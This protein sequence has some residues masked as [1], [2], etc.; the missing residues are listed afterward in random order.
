MDRPQYILPKNQEVANDCF[1]FLGIL[2]FCFLGMAFETFVLTQLWDLRSLSMVEAFGLILVTSLL[3]TQ[4]PP[5]ETGNIFVHAFIHPALLWGLGYL[6]Y[7]Y[8][9]V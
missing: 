3:T 1:K 5:K 9:M 7:T 2:L 4:L 6:A 8:F